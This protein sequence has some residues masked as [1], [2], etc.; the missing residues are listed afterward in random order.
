VNYAPVAA[1]DLYAT[2]EDTLLT[3]R[4]PGVLGNDTDAD[5][6]PL[7]TILLT[8]PAYGSLTLNKDGSFTYLPSLNYFGSIPSPTRPLTGNRRAIWRRSH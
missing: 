7:T 2:N 6:D 1:N 8:Q 4:P 5:G 3:I